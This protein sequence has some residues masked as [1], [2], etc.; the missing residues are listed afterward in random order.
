MSRDEMPMNRTGCFAPVNQKTI[1]TEDERKF[2]EY[3]NNPK[4]IGSTVILAQPGCKA[5]L[6]ARL[7]QQACYTNISVGHSVEFFEAL[8]RI[9]DDPIA[10]ENYIAEEGA[11]FKYRNPEKDKRMIQYYLYCLMS[12]GSAGHHSLVTDV[13]GDGNQLVEPFLEMIREMSTGTRQ[14]KIIFITT[15]Y[16]EPLAEAQFQQFRS[17]YELGDIILKIEDLENDPVDFLMKCN[18]RHYP[19]INDIN[20]VLKEYHETI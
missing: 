9:N 12:N 10:K 13:I 15:N 20:R 3:E 1:E 8:L 4:R 5:G 6:V 2:R 11:L 17:A 19:R 18:A 14:Y 7:L 16:R